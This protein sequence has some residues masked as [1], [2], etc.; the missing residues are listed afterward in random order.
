MPYTCIDEIC[1][2]IIN[3]NL[4]Q[5]HYITYTCLCH[6]ASHPYL[7]SSLDSSGRLLHRS[8]YNAGVIG[9]KLSFQ[10]PQENPAHLRHHSYLWIEI[11]TNH[12]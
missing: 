1:H 5:A 9:S 3:V 4:P 8:E 12:K 7:L 10:N 6:L 2:I 11:P